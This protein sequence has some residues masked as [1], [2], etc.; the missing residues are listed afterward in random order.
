VDISPKKTEPFSGYVTDYEPYHRPIR[1][2][3]N[4]SEALTWDIPKENLW[5]TT[6]STSAYVKGSNWIEGKSQRETWLKDLLALKKKIEQD[7]EKIGWRSSDDNVQTLEEK[8]VKEVDGQILELR[9]ELQ[10]YKGL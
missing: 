10:A 4:V 9:R 1:H 8:L 5:R 6:A 2:Y 7:C 3:T